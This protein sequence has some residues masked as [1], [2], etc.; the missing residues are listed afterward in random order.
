MSSPGIDP[1]SEKKKKKN[2]KLNINEWNIH[3]GLHNSNVKVP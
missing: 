2:K 1:E 3:C